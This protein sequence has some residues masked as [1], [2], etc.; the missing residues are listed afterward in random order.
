MALLLRK[1][2]DFRSWQPWLTGTVGFL[3]LLLVL[4]AVLTPDAAASHF[5]RAQQLRDAGQEQQALRLYELIVKTHPRSAFAP[6]SL[7]QEGEILTAQARRSGDR[8]LFREA[9]VVYLRLAEQYSSHSA[10]GEAL[11]SA[12]SIAINEVRDS[13]IATRCYQRLLEKYAGNSDYV[14]EATLRLGRIALQNGDG[15]KAQELLRRVLQEYSRFPERAAEA[16]YHLGVV[17]ETLVRNKSAA[18][19][20]YEATIRKWPRSVWASDAKERLGMMAYT[21]GRSTRPSRRVLLEI[22]AVPPPRDSS[23]AAALRVIMAARGLEISDAVWR[24]WS[25]APFRAG[26]APDSPNRAVSGDAAWE[27]VA[28]NA[29][30]VYS[31]KGVRQSAEAIELLRDELDAGHTPLI[32]ADGWLLVTGYDSARNQVFVRRKGNSAETMSSK[33]LVGKWRGGGEYSLLSFHMPNER[34][35]AVVHKTDTGNGA[36]DLLAPQYLYKMPS[37][38]RRD[39]HRRTLR[40]AA[41]LMRRAREDGVL[42]NLEALRA[43]RNELQTLLRVS[44]SPVPAPESTTEDD[45]PG[46]VEAPAAPGTPRVIDSSN[47]NNASVRWKSIRKWFGAPLKSWVES[48][49]D[50]AAFLDAANNE[51]GDAR[52]QHAAADFR[53]SMRHLNFAASALPSEDIFEND[54]EAA[55]RA[56]A[57]LLENIDAAL[58]A[59]QQA[60]TAMS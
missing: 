30:L 18:R 40:R 59:E 37:L 20:A 49:R 56:V 5:Y 36:P 54:P 11:L 13:K 35:S 10:G 46:S 31:R 25:L 4:R 42:L 58:Q 23:L 43:I 27:T 6:L 48:R 2:P 44:T 55:R 15:K 17:A 26:Y 52:A 34:L 50:A 28:A 16:Q 24:G 33:E 38:S 14:S 45:T 8:A 57:S 19:S 7:Q 29:G 39:A 3:V 47:M 12:G 32:D 53:D 22:G 9:I 21:D 1:R 41:A 60:A 51:L